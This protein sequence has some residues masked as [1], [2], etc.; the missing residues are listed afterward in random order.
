MH[1]F[2]AAR[3]REARRTQLKASFNRDKIAM[4]YAVWENK[5]GQVMKKLEVKKRLA[6]RKAAYARKLNVRRR[7]LM[8]LLTAENEFLA[9]KLAS[10]FETMEQRRE[11]LVRHANS[12]QE[13]RETDRLKEVE[14]LRA[15]QW[16]DSVDEIR[17]YQANMLT[18]RVAQERKQQLVWKEEREEAV[19]QADRLKEEEYA[20]RKEKLLRRELAEQA[21]LDERSDLTKRMLA[22][23]V[24]EVA[25]LKAR[26]EQEDA[27]ELARMRA[28]WAAENQAELDKQQ[29]RRDHAAEIERETAIFNAHKKELDSHKGDA[30][31]AEDLRLLHAVLKKEAAKEKEEQDLKA[32]RKKEMKDYQGMLKQMMI[33]EQ[34]DDSYLEQLLRDEEDKAWNKREKTWKAEAD[35]RAKLMREVDESRQSQIKW[36]AERRRKEEEENMNF[37]TKLL[38][39]TQIKI[40]E[41]EAKVQR[42]KDLRL[43]SSKFITA[44]IEA[45][46]VKRAKEREDEKERIRL[47]QEAA[48]LYTKKIDKLYELNLGVPNHKRKKV[49]WYY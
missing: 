47:E 26:Q 45:R 48:K 25:Y 18:R 29:A 16:R 27:E 28:R 23:Q 40:K 13:K 20:K 17:S 19:R 3:E 2:A 5:T 44:Q 37:A 46:K 4:G 39:D 6:S 33:K 15:I 49:Q 9:D 8:S 32:A 35:A 24:K 43:E 21:V 12:L 22:A 11:R 36:K 38:A 7:E 1:G 42:K 30:E 10:S 41:A 31:A 34:Q 14:R